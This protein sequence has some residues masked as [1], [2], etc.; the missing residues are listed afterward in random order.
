ME[1]IISDFN[2]VVVS[3][4]S[5]FGETLKKMNHHNKNITLVV[6]KNNRLLG[7]LT[8]GDI[9]KAILNGVTP[10]DNV[11]KAM[12]KTPFCL[13]PGYANG[14]MVRIMVENNIFHLPIVNEQKILKGIIFQQTFIRQN[15]LLCPVVIMA[16]GVGSRLFPLTEDKPKPLLTISGKPMIVHILEK[17][18]DE[19]AREIFICV[20]Y[21][22]TMIEEYLGDGSNYRVNIS[23]INETEKLGTAGALSLLP[24]ISSPFFVTNADV[25]ASI[26]L[27]AMYQFHLD[28]ESTL[29]MAIKKDQKDVP[30]GTVTLEHNSIV[31]L[32]EKPSIVYYINAGIYIVD[33]HSVKE[34]PTKQ[35]YNMT[36]FVSHL[37]S[38]NMKISGYLINGSW[39]DIGQFKDY[40]LAN[41][42]EMIKA[43]RPPNLEKINM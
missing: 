36:D 27:K 20:N 1:S 33:N 21:K 15:I 41:T 2:D 4:H 17:F 18:R 43:Q 3:D 14:E 12:N 24:E 23:Y 10:K 11:Q 37:L 34:I 5:S 16:G 42:N 19:G 30:Y 26:S 28:N 22:S 29:T 9:R 6:D 31:N 35:F 32:S 38:N 25:I 13:K 7:I 39:T 40:G 8:D